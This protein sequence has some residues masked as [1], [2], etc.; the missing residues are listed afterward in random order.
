V[1]SDKYPQRR[2]LLHHSKFNTHLSSSTVL[3]SPIR[4][5]WRWWRCRRTGPELLDM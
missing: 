4:R 1:T 5:Q 3:R 2:P